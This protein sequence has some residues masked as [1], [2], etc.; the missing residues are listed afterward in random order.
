MA[1]K[2]YQKYILTGPDKDYLASLKTPKSIEES[3]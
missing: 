3:S 1:E 2:K